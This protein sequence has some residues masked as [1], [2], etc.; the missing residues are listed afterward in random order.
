MNYAYWLQD[1][2]TRLEVETIHIAVVIQNPLLFGYTPEMIVECYQRHHEPLGVEAVARVEIM[3]DLIKNHRWCRIRFSPA[4]ELWVV[5]LSYLTDLFRKHL[6]RF[7]NDPD[8]IGKHPHA[9]VRITELFA[10]SGL[11]ISKLPVRSFGESHV[12]FEN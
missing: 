2:G 3:T 8:V 9:D 1:S 7:F 12:L 6:T 10:G 4:T 11:M 5:E